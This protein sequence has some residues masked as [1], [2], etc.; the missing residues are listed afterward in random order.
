MNEHY[1][2]K[3]PQSRIKEKTFSQT[4]KGVTL[5]FT[6]VSGV[7]S[8]DGRI[9][10]ASELL[11]K[12]F[13]P[14]MGHAGTFLDLG[15][16]YGVIGLFLKAFFPGL[17]ATL[18]DVNNRAV[19]YSRQNAAINNLDVNVVASDLYDNLGDVL[20]DDV[21]SNP[22]VAA[23]KKLT[24]RLITE[25]ARHINEGGSLWLVAFHNKGGAT[26]RTKMAEEF[27]NVEDVEKSGGIRVYRSVKKAL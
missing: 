26:L 8:F 9:D 27:G 13:T 18:S 24:F 16:G 4:I 25:S 14:S 15:C 3:D 2:T 17:K 19:E 23:G 10:R 20:F 7:F 6:A 5:N 12:S 21:V 22:P 1:Y 11:I